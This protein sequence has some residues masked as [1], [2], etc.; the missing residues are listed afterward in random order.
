MNGEL[1]EIARAETVEREPCPRCGASPGSVCRADS[2]VHHTGRYARIPALRSGPAIRD[3]RRDEDR[4]RLERI[5][6]AREA[7][8]EILLADLRSN[9]PSTPR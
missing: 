9:P 3:H 4:L 5:R 2:G 8:V 1:D 6:S 7:L